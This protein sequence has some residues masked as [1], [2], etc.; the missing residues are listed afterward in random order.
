M[1]IAALYDIHGNLPAL[2]AVLAEIRAE[3]VDRVIVGGDVLPGPMPVETL[4]CLQRLEVPV[5][6]IHGNGETDVLTCLAGRDPVRVP[7][8]HR[9]PIHWCARQLSAD[10]ARSIGVWPLTF[11]LT[12]DPLG[13]ILFCHATARSDYEIFTR[14]TP[15][16]GLLDWLEPHGAP[17]VV[18]GH[19]HMQ[20]DRHVGSFRVIN[21]GSVGMP[22]GQPG[23]YWLLIDRAVELRRTAYDIVA[24]AQR[25]SRTSFP[26]AREFA[27]G[28]VVQPAGAEMMEALFDRA[29]AAARGRPNQGGISPRSS[30]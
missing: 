8:A 11:G 16:A 20:F 13:E 2:E 18:C 15:D 25:I 24:A 19:T 30:P 10:Q 6:F 9:E 14:N 17:T 22:F 23:A 27:R 12:A 1:R 21:A 7:E 26:G 5:H 28:S 29:A 3:G 4:D